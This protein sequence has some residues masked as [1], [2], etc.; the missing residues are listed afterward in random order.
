MNF[1]KW[2]GFIVFLGSLYILW[3]LREFLLLLL[4][5]VILANAL[6]VLVVKLQSLSEVI[7]KKFDQPRFCL[8]RGYAVFASLFL[9]GLVIWTW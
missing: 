7:A 2:S 6:N 1:R 9:V 5:A 8:S 3:Q 4:T